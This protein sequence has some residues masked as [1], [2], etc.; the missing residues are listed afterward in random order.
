MKIQKEKLCVVCEK[1]FIPKSGS[2]LYCSVECRKEAARKK[3]L[4]KQRKKHLSIAEIQRIGRK[5]NL[6]YGETVAAI[7]KGDIEI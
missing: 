3:R 1:P 6:N 7:E 4:K 2:G 5:H